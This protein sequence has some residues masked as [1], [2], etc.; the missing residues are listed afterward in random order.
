[1]NHAQIFVIGLCIC[2]GGFLAQSADD[3]SDFEK[4]E[5]GKHLMAASIKASGGAKAIRKETSRK[6]TGTFQLNNGAAWPML[7]LEKAP[8]LKRSEVKV[9]DY[10]TVIEGCDGKIAWKQEPGEQAR[11]LQGPERAEKINEAKFYRGLELMTEFKTA[12]FLGETKRNGMLYYKVAATYADEP[13]MTYF[14]N[15]HSNHMEYMTI[16][17]PTYG[18]IEIELNDNKIIETGTLYPFEMVIKVG[19]ENSQTV[20]TFNTDKVELNVEIDDEKFTKPAKDT[21]TTLAVP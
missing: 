12:V 5:K 17:H 16:D 20:M 1:M 11:S 13:D 10:G 9:P 6:V 14:I 7:V 8:Q 3:L 2:I 21:G 4:A 15:A 19:P 18:K